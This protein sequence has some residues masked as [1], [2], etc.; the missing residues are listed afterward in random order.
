VTEVGG[1][2]TD[3]NS[4][5]KEV[6]GVGVT[7]GMNDKFGVFFS[8]AAFYFGNAPGLPGAAVTHRLFAVVEGLF[9]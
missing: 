3:V 9:E 7:Q 6:G 2:L 8:E 5:F 4:C 1:D